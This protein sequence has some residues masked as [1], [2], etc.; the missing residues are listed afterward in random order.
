MT[1]RPAA[2]AELAAL[3][4]DGA[5]GALADMAAI[6]L[7]TS[8]HYWLTRADFTTAFIA[9]GHSPLSGRPLGHIRWR[10]AARALAAGRLPCTGSETAILQIAASLAAGLPV[11]LRDA[12]TG[13][14]HANLTAVAGAIMTAGGHHRP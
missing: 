3:L 10:A 1:R 9:T 7:L 5:D 11:R 6:Q 12:V 13:L 14:D 8:H 2:P 4:A